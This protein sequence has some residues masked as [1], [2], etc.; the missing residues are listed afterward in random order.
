MFSRVLSYSANPEKRR[1][2]S[3]DVPEPQLGS[4]CWEWMSFRPH[5][6]HYSVCSP[7]K[8][9]QFAF[10]WCVCG[11][12]ERQPSLA[13][14]TAGD[15][16][17][18][19]IFIT[20]KHSGYTKYTTWFNHLTPNDDYSGRIAPLTPKRCILYIYSTNIGTDSFKHG[21][22]SPFFPFKMQFV[23]QI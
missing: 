19:Y 7:V 8:M 18:G 9:C 12:S 14:E 6:A 17:I 15:K 20:S 22:H 5:N 16:D 23:S 11:P 1:R 3:A 4:P 2:N 10:G 13:G 21:I